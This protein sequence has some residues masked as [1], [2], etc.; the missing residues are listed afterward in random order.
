MEH[1]SKLAT[2]QKIIIGTVLIAI[3]FAMPELMIIY[4]IGGFD[5]M[6]GFFLM[7]IQ[8]IKAYVQSKLADIKESLTILYLS[9]SSTLITDKRVFVI[10]ASFFILAFAMTGSI[11]LSSLFLYPGFLLESGIGSI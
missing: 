7:Y 10:Q 9:A 1:W 3:A 4:D 2:W 5:L 8:S 11:Y 6:F